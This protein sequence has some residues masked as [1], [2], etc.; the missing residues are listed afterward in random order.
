MFLEF[1]EFDT[2]EYDERQLLKVLM[3]FLDEF[4]DSRTVLEN[5]RS[6]RVDNMPRHN[7]RQK[8]ERHRNTISSLFSCIRPLD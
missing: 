1:N 2:S 6:R 4:M 5:I 3:K 8:S 7:Y